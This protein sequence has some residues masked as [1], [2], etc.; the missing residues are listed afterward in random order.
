MDFFNEYALLFAVSL[1]VVVI[2][3]IQVCLFIIAGERGTGLLPGF[4]KYPSIE[5]G[6]AVEVAERTPVVSETPTVATAV[7]SS[8]DEA[9]RVAA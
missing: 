9:E 7:E 4:D 6:R 8:N 3:G 5:L 1:P 2:V